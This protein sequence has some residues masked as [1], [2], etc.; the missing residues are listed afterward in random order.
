MLICKI[1]LYNSGLDTRQS[2]F[3]YFIR[4]AEIVEIGPKS[5]NSGVITSSEH[6]GRRF[7]RLGG[8]RSAVAPPPSTCCWG[9]GCHHQHAPAQLHLAGCPGRSKPRRRPARSFFVRQHLVGGQPLDGGRPRDPDPQGIAAA[10]NRQTTAAPRLEGHLGPDGLLL[11]GAWFSA[12][13]SRASSFVRWFGRATSAARRSC[14]AARRRS[15]LRTSTLLVAPRYALPVDLWTSPLISWAD[16][17]RP[18][19]SCGQG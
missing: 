1:A 18:A 5:L 15:L 16:Q 6:G 7:L 19:A 9:G 10:A 2:L 14:R 12:G 11:L 13:G 17:R 4:G 3:N 8:C